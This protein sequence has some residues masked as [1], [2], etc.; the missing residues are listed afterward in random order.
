MDLFAHGG[1]CVSI[2]YTM[3]LIND[4]LNKHV[5]LN[6]VHN[7]TNMYEIIIV[8]ETDTKTTTT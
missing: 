6:C 4:A 2:N 3:H 5:L 1:P 7:V 8:S